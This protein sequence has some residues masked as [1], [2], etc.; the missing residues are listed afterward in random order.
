MHFQLRSV[1][2]TY[3]C[4]LI[5]IAL[6]TQ[7]SEEL[8]P[9]LGAIHGRHLLAPTSTCSTGDINLYVRSLKC[10]AASCQ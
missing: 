1:F 9:D 5:H 7:E 2:V 6:A 3:L 8:N 10:E 4:V